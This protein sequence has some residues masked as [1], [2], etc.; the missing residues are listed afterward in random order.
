[1]RR[2]PMTAVAA[3]GLAAYLVAQA[4]PPAGDCPTDR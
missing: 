4:G 1:M 2:T 3:L